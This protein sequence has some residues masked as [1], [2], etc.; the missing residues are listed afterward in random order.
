MKNSNNQNNHTMK[1]SNKLLLIAFFVILAAQITLNVMATNEF[2]K[3][4]IDAIENGIP[5][6]NQIQSDSIVIRIR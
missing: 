6:D 4:R 2:A 3:A 5:I 1:T